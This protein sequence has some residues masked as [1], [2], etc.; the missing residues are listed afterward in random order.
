ETPSPQ[1]VADAGEAGRISPRLGL[2]LLAALAG[3]LLLLAW[4]NSRVTLQLQ[5]DGWREIEKGRVNKNTVQGDREIWEGNRTLLLNEQKFVLQPAVYDT[6]NR[7]ALTALGR[8]GLF[9][10][11]IPGGVAFQTA[12][13]GG[14]LASFDDRWRWIDGFMLPDYKRFEPTA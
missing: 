10:S 12:V 7:A 14:D 13:P 6:L 9:T 11:P 8:S 3:G 2:V 5:L 1:M 4:L